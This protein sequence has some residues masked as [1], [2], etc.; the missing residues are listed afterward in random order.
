[1]ARDEYPE[2]RGAGWLTFA[3]TIISI[4]GLVSV[5]AGTAA[6]LNSEAFDLDKEVVFDGLKTWGWIVLILGLLQFVTVV[7]IQQRTEWGRWGGI[8]LAGLSVIGQLMWIHANPWW[9]LI[10]IV[11]DILVIYALTV[12]GGHIKY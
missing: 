10:V 11:L 3:M 5:I 9:A 6:L 2:E 8:A 7:G 4:A 12:Y 1:M